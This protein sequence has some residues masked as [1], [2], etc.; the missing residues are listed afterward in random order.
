MAKIVTLNE[1]IKYFENFAT[2]HLQIQEFGY[3]DTSL[4]SKSKSSNYPLMWTHR[5][6]SS[7]IDITANRTTVPNHS[8][9]ILFVD[10]IITINNDSQGFESENTS[11]I[12]SDQFQ[13]VQDF[14]DY[15]IRNLNSYGITLGEQSVTLDEIYDETVDKVAGWQLTFELKTM[16]HN[17]STPLL[18]VSNSRD[19]C[20]VGTIKNSDDSYTNTVA[21]GG[22][23][24]LDDISLI[25][26]GV[27]QSTHPS[28]VDIIATFS[29]GDA[30]V[31]N[32]DDSYV[33]SVAGGDS[34]ELP[35]IEIEINGDV[36][37]P[38]PSVEDLSFELIDQYDNVLQVDDVTGDVI[39]VDN[40]VTPSNSIPPLKTGQVTSYATNDDGDIEFGRDVDFTTLSWNNPFGNTNRF[41]DTSGGQTYANN[42]YIDWTSY[43]TVN[44][45]VTGYLFSQQEYAT[46]GAKNWN[47]WMSGQPYTYDSKNDW[48]VTNVRQVLQLANFGIN[49]LYNYSP[50]NYSVSNNTATLITSTTWASSSV[51]CYT[52]HTNNDLVLRSKSSWSAS[53]LL[54]REYTLAELGL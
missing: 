40:P 29:C 21:S 49:Y 25:I 51:N 12:L 34:L 1:L 10:R 27:T 46:F 44:G 3:G 47:N 42:V 53:A 22:Q 2:N 35:D 45:K 26:N 36:L 19:L 15:I 33:A 50:I 31:S 24:T 41:T 48:Y 8:F 11:E 28:A 43:D 5:T 6:N 52:V 9:S 16:Q 18:P 4:I 7:S 23:L 13:I 32:S 38:Y 54:Y 20:A 30:S 39:T 37:G 14:L 17:C